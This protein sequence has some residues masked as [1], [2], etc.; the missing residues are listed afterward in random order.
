MQNFEIIVFSSRSFTLFITA[1][2]LPVLSATHCSEFE[3]FDLVSKKCKSVNWCE[4]GRS[5][6]SIIQS[7]I[8]RC[9][10]MRGSEFLNPSEL[11]EAECINN[12][13]H[14][15]AGFINK[16]IGNLR[17]PCVSFED[18]RSCR[19]L[20]NRVPFCDHEGC[21]C[22]KNVAVN[23]CGDSELN[24]CLENQVCEDLEDGFACNDCPDENMFV[25]NGFCVWKKKC[26]ELSTLSTNGTLS[27]V[28]PCDNESETVCVDMTGY[29]HRCDCI[30]QAGFKFAKNYIGECQRACRIG[31]IRG[32]NGTCRVLSC[33]D[34]NACADSAKCENIGHN[35]YCL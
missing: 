30:E 22:I 21:F 28:G 8:M 19:G 3:I 6:K 16:E 31:R 26:E 24:D 7:Q 11:I 1:I 14:C 35:L 32:T 10:N 27:Y 4:Y 18:M 23:E 29:K 9:R 33:V 17:T 25:K 5:K 2:F 12:E 34:D 20:E 13:C 15:K